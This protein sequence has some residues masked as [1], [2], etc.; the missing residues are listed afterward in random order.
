VV[1]SNGVEEDNRAMGLRSPVLLDQGFGAGSAFGTNG[2]PTAVLVDEE[3][4]IASE[5]VGGAP[6]VLALARGEAPPGVQDS[7]GGAGGAAAIP[8]GEPAP[9]VALPD[10]SGKTVDLADFRGHDTLVLFWNPGCGFCLQMLGDLKSWEASPPPGAP[11]LLVVSTGTPEANRAQG[12]KSPVLLDQDFATGS[13]FGA[14]GTPSA[15][16]VDA[17]GQVASGV[18][19]GGPAVLALAG[20]KSS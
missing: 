20:T 13:L 11:R 15:V 16:L 2:T 5:V 6:S 4:R 19:V 8:I 3:G 14:S 17:K 10:L 9:A 1:V 18:A 12:L 7:C